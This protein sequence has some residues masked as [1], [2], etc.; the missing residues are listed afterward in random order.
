VRVALYA[1]VSTPGSDKNATNYGGQERQ[2]PEKQLIYSELSLKRGHEISGEY[3][4]RLSGKD[5]NLPALE[6]VKKAASVM[7]STPSSSFSWTE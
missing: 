6:A 7:S 4:D 3:V 1:G 2:D 5:A